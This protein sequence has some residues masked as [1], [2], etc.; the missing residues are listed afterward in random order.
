VRFRH[1]LIA[2]SCAAALA[3][4]A[5]GGDDDAGPAAAEGAG[6]AQVVS[7]DKEAWVLPNLVGPGQVRLTDFRGVPVVV[8][9]F[10]SW[11]TPCQR[12]LPAFHR[13]STD[14]AGQVA[15]VGVNSNDGG[16]GLPLA[17]ETGVTEWPLARDQGGRS[18][19]GLARALESRGL[20]T[21]AFYDA[22]GTLVG[23]T[24][25]EVSEEELREQIE[26]LFGIPAT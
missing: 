23:R 18:E 25:S 19:D 9:F 15:F 20:P 16:N 21:T 8:N 5:C 10:A 7:T 3:L 24:F 17:E 13:V 1:R 12:E 26:E 2:V 4:G 11:C 6:G 22:E 14:L